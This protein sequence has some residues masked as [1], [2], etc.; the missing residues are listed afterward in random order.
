[1]AQSLGILVSSD[2]HLD[3]VINLTEAAHKKEK[4]I[5][6]FFTGDGVKLGLQPDFIK[7]VGKAKL[8][9][10]D[11]SF[12]AHGFHGREDEVPGVGFKDF[13]TQA[14]NAEMSAECDR[15]LVL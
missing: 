13:A 9:V 4:E 1:M 14:R 11:V 8:A 6:I 5:H 2:K 3:Y 7:L 12:R 15:Y 10:C